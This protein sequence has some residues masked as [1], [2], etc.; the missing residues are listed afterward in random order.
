MTSKQIEDLVFALQEQFRNEYDEDFDIVIMGEENDRDVQFCSNHLEYE[1]NEVIVNDMLDD[2]LEHYL[3][4]DA[5]DD[6]FRFHY[7]RKHW[8]SL[9]ENAHVKLARFVIEQGRI[10]TDVYVDIRWKDSREVEKN[11]CI[12]CDKEVYD[13]TDAPDF[14]ST[15]PLPNGRYD[16]SYLY[17]CDSIQTFL[18][19]LQSDN[20]EDFEII[21]VH[22]WD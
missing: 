8:I 17:C 15:K 9:W 2:E 18:K 12:C 16:S 4:N 6:M 5:Y 13:A 22:G 20:G 3:T 10:P 19:L 1:F 21:E 14:D 7:F 11:I